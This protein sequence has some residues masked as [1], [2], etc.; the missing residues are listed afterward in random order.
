MCKLRHGF[1]LIELL[2]VVAIIGI[3]AAIAV[4]NFLNAQARAK[5][6]RSYADMRSIFTAI[7]SMRLDRNVLLV[8]FWDDDSAEG[9][10]RIA[11]IFSGV[12]G[13]HND[14]GGTKGL[15]AP[16]TT[17][18]AYIATIPID[19]FA[20]QTGYGFN[21]STSTFI[22][23]DQEPPITY[24]Y[25][26][27]DPKIAGCDCGASYFGVEGNEE[28]VPLYKPGDFALIGYGPDA[29]RNNPPGY[30]YPYSASNGLKSL[31]DLW[32]RNGGM[33]N[34]SY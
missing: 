25:S 5:I 8:D 13:G 31:G 3:L 9:Q 14:R 7:E 16:L 24:L 19:P 33:T 1:T 4:P 32:I 27:D 18:I 34:E 20:I 10:T 2:I 15:L 12:G 26:D 23:A 30:G 29:R 17:P 22:A 6:A 28:G 11:E 21:D